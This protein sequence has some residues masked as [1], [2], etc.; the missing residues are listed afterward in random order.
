M[1]TRFLNREDEQKR[2]RRAMHAPGG[3]LAVI[4]GRRRC[5]KSTLLQRV[6]A[7]PDVYYLADQKE[8]ALQIRDLAAEIDKTV[9]N[10]SSAGYAT[11]DSLLLNLNDRLTRR[12]SLCLDEFPYLAQLSPALPR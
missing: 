3:A 12:I 1:T 5:G 7:G 9:P 8:P 11:W 4:Y 6:I 2:L 10:F